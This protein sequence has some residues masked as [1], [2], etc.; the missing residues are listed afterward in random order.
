MDISSYTL[1]TAI[2][3]H[4][5]LLHIAGNMLFLWIFGDNV[6]DQ[7][8]HVTYLIFYLVGGVVASIVYAF[9]FSGSTRP[10]GRGQWRYRR[11]AWRLHPPLSTLDRAV[12]PDLWAIPGRWWGSGRHLDRRLVPDAGR[13]FRELDQRPR[14]RHA[15]NVAFMAHVGGF[16]FGLIVTWLIRRERGQEVVHW[17]HRQWFNRSFRNWVLL[18]VLLSLLAGIGQYEVNRGAMAAGAFH[19]VLGALVVV[20]AFVDGFARLRGRPGLLGSAG[21]SR[22]LAILQIIAAISV[23]GTLIAI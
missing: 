18:I 22:L 15:I 11:G 9:V 6:E 4:A 10:A 20:I 12:D 17:D 1:V 13:L 19:A 7:L 8:G 14:H 2:F 23:A 21:A 5:G 3:L 16:A